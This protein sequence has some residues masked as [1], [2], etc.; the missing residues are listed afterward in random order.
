[1]RKRNDIRKAFPVTTIE[2][3]DNI[4]KIC[5]ERQDTWAEVVKTTVL[6][7]HDL[8]AADAV[9]HQSCNVNFRTGRQ[10]PKDYATDETTNKKR[11]T[12]RPQNKVKHDA[13]TAVIRYKKTTKSNKSLLVISVLKCKNTSKIP[14][15]Q[16]MGPLIWRTCWRDILGP[17]SYN[18]RKW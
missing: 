12:G 2:T 8:P 18:G 14:I 7:V 3:K 13:F 10:I 15:T 9:Y 11:K 5:A 4:L 1:M 16:L 6:H 17:Y